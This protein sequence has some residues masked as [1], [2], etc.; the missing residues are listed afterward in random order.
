[1]LEQL[2]MMN[3]WSLSWVAPRIDSLRILRVVAISART[4]IGCHDHSIIS[5]MPLVGLTQDCQPATQL[6]T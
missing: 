1:M 3:T 5:D 4:S 2:I 6:D